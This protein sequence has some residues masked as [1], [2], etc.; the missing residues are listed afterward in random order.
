MASLMIFECDLTKH[1][2]FAKPYEE[3]PKPFFAG[4]EIKNF[5]TIYKNT[6]TYQQYN[7]PLLE[8]FIK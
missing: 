4:I 8:Q 6:K 3:N 7:C 1:Y 2:S 5:L